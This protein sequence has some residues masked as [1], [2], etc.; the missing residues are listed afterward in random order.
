MFFT[1]ASVFLSILNF[2]ELTKS[3]YEWKRSGAER[4]TTR[5]R[6]KKEEL[7]I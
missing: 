4:N 5:Q 1:A 6:K 3:W 7:A 2:L